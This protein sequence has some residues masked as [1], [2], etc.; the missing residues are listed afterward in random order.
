M[1]NIRKFI[2]FKIPSVSFFWKNVA[3][4]QVWVKKFSRVQ[5]S[6]KIL[7]Q[8]KGVARNVVEHEI[9]HRN[10]IEIIFFSSPESREILGLRG[11]FGFF[12]LAGFYIH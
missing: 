3:K 9:L 2:N 8:E 7:T 10:D 6:K 5:K 1:S 11:H 4:L 12:G